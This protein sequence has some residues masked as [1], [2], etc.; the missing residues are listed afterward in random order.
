LSQIGYAFQYHKFCVQHAVELQCKESHVHIC[1][2]GGSL[3]ESQSR[4]HLYAS[5][6][7]QSPTTSTILTFCCVPTHNCSLAP[8]LVPIHSYLPRWVRVVL[9]WILLTP[10]DYD[11]VLPIAN[12]AIL[13]DVYE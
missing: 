1:S 10:L 4:L 7:I 2:K 5:M 8:F 12:F 9:H 6:S 13:Y 3:S 11:Y